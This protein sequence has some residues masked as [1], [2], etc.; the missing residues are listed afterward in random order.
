MIIKDEHSYL[1]EQSKRIRNKLEIVEPEYLAEY[2]MEMAKSEERE[3]KSQTTR[4]LMH[5][6]KCEYQTYKTTPSWLNAIRDSSNTIY[7]IISE[8]KSLYNK[9]NDYFND[10]YKRAIQK[11]STETGIVQS[12]FPKVCPWDKDS[13]YKENF[14]EDFIAQH[15]P[16][17]S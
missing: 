8:S 16:V 9:Y 11:A 3:L 1:I 17:K 10:C 2:L 15:S 4:C 13:I 7:D 14:I 5:M 12:K 6:L